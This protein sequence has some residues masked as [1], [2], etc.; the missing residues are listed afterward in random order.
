MSG[1]P[2]QH[3]ADRAIEI[4]RHMMAGGTIKEFAYMNNITE[5]AAR[6]HLQ[7][8]GWRIFWLSEQER[9]AIRKMRQQLG[10]IFFKNAV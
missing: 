4:E 5:G 3:V 7:K 10:T 8:I 9:D 6:N 1:K 2:Q